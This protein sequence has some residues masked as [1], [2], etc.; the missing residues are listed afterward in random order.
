MTSPNGKPLPS[1]PIE[2]AALVDGELSPAARQRLLDWLAEHPEAA[3][4]LRDQRLLSRQNVELWN[5]VSPPM[6]SNAHWQ[7]VLNHIE[8]AVDRGPGVRHR[9]RR[10]VLVMVLGPLAAAAAVIAFLV[11]GHATPSIHV[12]MASDLDDSEMLRIASPAEIEIVSIRPAD[13]G[14]LVI[15]ELPVRETLVLASP[16]DVRLDG[17][18]PAPDGE[19]PGALPADGPDAPMVYPPPPWGR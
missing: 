13:S 8:D 15:G 17:M 4:E 18:T 2:L 1:T 9:R 6:P 3:G 19:L 12:P 11:F 10:G 7:S 5:Q 16:L 14:A